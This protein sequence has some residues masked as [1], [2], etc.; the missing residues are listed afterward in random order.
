M[1]MSRMSMNKQHAETNTSEHHEKTMWPSFFK[2]EDPAVGD[3][4]EFED[5]N[6]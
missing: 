5:A 4:S 6:K 2:I 3:V 1:T